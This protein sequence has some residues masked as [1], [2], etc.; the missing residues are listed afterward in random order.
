MPT[1][2]TAGI[3]EGISFGDFILHCARNFGALIHMRD[4]SFKAEIQVRD[5]ENTYYIERLKECKEE[6]E[7]LENMGGEEAAKRCDAENERRY[8]EFLKR[9]GDN[10]R[11]LT[12]LT[13]M[14][15]K[16]DAWTPP[17]KEHEGLKK[18]ML[19]QIDETISFDCDIPSLPKR[20]G[21]AEWLTTE[22]D[23]AKS[24]VEYNE[25][26]LRKNRERNKDTNVWIKQLFQSIGREAEF[27]KLKSVSW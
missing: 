26:Q 8:A 24:S 11:K 7:E 19:S 1:G 13:E 18:F 6:L 4:D 20:I 22:L 27:K 17:S 10:Q 2:Y 25:K 15:A 23:C 5:D 21:P 9:V 3:Y 16:A 14:R 12:Q